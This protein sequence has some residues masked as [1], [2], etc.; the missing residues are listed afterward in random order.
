MRT[1]KQAFDLLTRAYI[2]NEIEPYECEACFCGNL[3]NND[4]FMDALSCRRSYDR[5]ES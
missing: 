4:G 2:N 5:M 1:Y 3:L